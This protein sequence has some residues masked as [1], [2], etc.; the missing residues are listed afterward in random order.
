MVLHHL[1]GSPRL[2]KV[3]SDC[4]PPLAPN[5]WLYLPELMLRMS[6]SFFW[7]NPNRPAK[8]WPSHTPAMVMPS[9]KLLH[10]FAA[11][12]ALPTGVPSTKWGRFP[13]FSLLK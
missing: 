13:R 7:S 12:E 3:H 4:Q 11:Y 10:N 6:A 5:T 2:P 9:T 1:H 8:A